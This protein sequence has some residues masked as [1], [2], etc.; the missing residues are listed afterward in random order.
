MFPDNPAA[1]TSRTAARYLMRLI[2]YNDA[3]GVLG[4]SECSGNRMR[5]KKI[6][7][8]VRFV[9]D[10]LMVR[11][12]KTL[13]TPRWQGEIFSDTLGDHIVRCVE[14]AEALPLDSGDKILIKRLLVVH[15][16]PRPQV[17]E[18]DFPLLDQWMKAEKALW[19]VWMGGVRPEAVVARTL[20]LTDDLE[21]F[22]NQLTRW[23]GSD[24]Y[25]PEKMPS[26][27]KVAYTFDVGRMFWENL[28][29]AEVDPEAAAVCRKI[30]ELALWWVVKEWG[31]VPAER[32]P[33]AM[34]ERFA[35]AEKNLAVFRL[36]PAES[37][38]TGP[39]EK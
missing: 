28:G 15:E 27:R 14:K 38:G 19:G 35:W 31:K 30:L 36:G 4:R 11:V 3:A 16:L 5:Y 7:S 34:V 9:P 10:D 17:S 22:H 25:Q 20:D 39:V 21:I 6:V 37:A 23:V 26:G 24:D 29:G 13:K 12:V 2:V 8:P 32:I 33:E 18:P 1:K